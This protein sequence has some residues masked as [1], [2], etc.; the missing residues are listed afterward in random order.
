MGRLRNELR[1]LGIAENTM[2]WF[3]SDNGPEAREHNGNNGSAGSFKGRKRSLYEGGIRVPGLLEWPAI[4]DKP[5]ATD[6]PCVTSDY[7]PTIL[8]ALDI[9]LP[10]RT[11]DGINLLPLLKGENLKREQPIFFMLRNNQCAITEKYKLISKDK[12]KT[13]ELYDLLKDKEEENDIIS[14]K[15]SIADNLQAQLQNWIDDVS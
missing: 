11:L 13:Y 3:C 9:P 4:V 2:L 1:T 5:K 6:F 10:A 14:K 7:F 12:G 8:A 15:K